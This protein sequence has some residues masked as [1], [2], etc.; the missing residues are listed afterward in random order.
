[1]LTSHGSSTPRFLYVPCLFLKSSLA[2]LM[3]FSRD[4]LHIC[5]TSLD[6]RWGDRT[7]SC[8]SPGFSCAHFPSC[9]I[10]SYIRSVTCTARI[11]GSDLLYTLART[12][13]SPMQLAH[14]PTLLNWCWLPLCYISFP[15]AWRTR[16]RYF[17]LLQ[18]LCDI[19]IIDRTCKKKNLLRL[20]KSNFVN[21]LFV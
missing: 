4:F 16:R 5:F 13:C 21:Q 2:F 15:G 7:S 20:R 18:T 14:C 8:S 19:K 9:Q 12:L 10:I 17:Q 1:M 11:T 3:Q 6:C